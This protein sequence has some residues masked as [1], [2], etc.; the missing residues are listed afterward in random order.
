MGKR[1]S[2]RKSSPGHKLGQMIGNFFESVLGAQLERTARELGLYLDRKGPRSGVRGTHH[3]VTWRDNQGNGHDLDYVLERGGSA[4]RQGRP[5]AFIELAWRRYT[6]H[7]RNKTGEIEGALL[8][9]RDS[10]RSCLFLGAILAG[11]YTEGGIRQLSSH[12]IHVLHIE[13]EQVIAAFRT[14]GVDLDYPENASPT[15]KQRLIR[16]MG[17]LSKADQAQVAAAFEA[18]I[19]DALDGFL[20]SLRA[21]VSRQ[22]DSVVVI[23]AYGSPQ[24]VRT[25]ADAVRVIQGFEPLPQPSSSLQFLRFE[26]IVRYRDGTEIDARAL[27]TR[28][29]AL[30]FLAEFAPE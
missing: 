2:G 22:V 27:P 23:G 24:T 8:H 16:Q 4:E 25:I 13:Y 10:H 3:K 28:E 18:T 7:S 26:I 12:G 20:G 29:A 5:V 6:K 17:R 30:Q 1:V 19:R 21:S 15:V 9:L 11:E 14:R